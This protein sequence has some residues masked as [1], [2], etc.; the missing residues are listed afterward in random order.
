MK[1]PCWLIAIGLLWAAGFWDRSPAAQLAA[2]ASAFAAPGK[3]CAET[4]LRAAM[5]ASNAGPANA[6][7]CSGAGDAARPAATATR[8]SAAT[9]R[10]VRANSTAGSPA[11]PVGL[12]REM[13]ISNAF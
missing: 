1:Y 2:D 5:N 7:S 6:P 3:R 12:P 13:F 9:R 10:A 11:R 8:R 4:S